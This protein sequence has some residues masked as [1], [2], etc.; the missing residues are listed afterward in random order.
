MPWRIIKSEYSP[1]DLATLHDDELIAVEIA[2]SKE[3]A[4]PSNE[5]NP[6][7]RAW[8]K[9][10]PLAEQCDGSGD[11]VNLLPPDSRTSPHWQDHKHEG[12]P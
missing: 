10:R 4:A 5:N 2:L 8:K 3:A 11:P 12:R 1:L 6:A 9:I 7:W